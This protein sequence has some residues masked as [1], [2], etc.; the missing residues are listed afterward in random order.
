[1]RP[2][3]RLLGGPEMFSQRRY[4]TFLLCGLAAALIFGPGRAEDVRP[5]VN[6]QANQEK[7]VK[8]EVDRTVARINTM[9]AVL[10]YDRLDAGAEKLLMEEISGTLAGLS[11]EQIAEVITRLETAAKSPD[12][13]VSQQERGVAYERHREV[14]LTLKALLAKFDAV[15]TLDQAAERV[16]EAARQQLEMH[17]KSWDMAQKAGELSQDLIN[18]KRRLDNIRSLQNESAGLSDQQ[19][20]L[21]ADVANLFKQL[22]ALKDQLPPDQQQRL[23]QAKAAAEQQKLLDNLARAA[24]DLAN[25]R[26]TWMRPEAWKSAADTQEKAATDLA[27][28]ARALRSPTDKVTALREA[29][30]QIE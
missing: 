13:K 23:K 19:K 3:G 25:G 10:R 12:D 15:K 21:R 29:R 11:R 8:V 4:V 30:A 14:I 7:A 6:A 16:E 20:D 26:R 22:D 1:M 24:D 28:L 18:P 5:N 27:Q 17:L 9:L 2:D